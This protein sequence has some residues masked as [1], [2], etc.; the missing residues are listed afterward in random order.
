MG[1]PFAEACER[2]RAPLLEVLKEA[3][4]A[5]H[6]VLEVGS[7]TGQHAVYFAAGLPHLTWQTSELPALHAGIEAWLAEASLPNLRAPLA[8]DVAGDWPAGP[9]DG[10]FTAN[11]L[12]IMSWAH[13]EKFFAGV[14]RVLAA[15]GVL[16]TYGPFNY[17]GAYTSES[18]AQFDRWLK[19]RDSASGIRDFENVCALARSHGFG[20][21]RDIAMPAN[22]RTLLLRRRLSVEAG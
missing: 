1:K 3:F 20:L 22:N 9:F 2:N 21:E 4:A 6:A 17:S 19:S 14:G 7:G 15:G 13:V 16:A 5:C 12:H 8:L 18:N 10:V 11:T